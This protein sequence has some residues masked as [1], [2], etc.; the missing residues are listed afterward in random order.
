MM[1]IISILTG[2]VTGNSAVL[3]MGPVAGNILSLVAL[4][5]ACA[6]KG[7]SYHPLL[8]L[9]DEHLRSM[10]RLMVPLA[11]SS[12][13]LEVNQI[14]DK[15]LASSLAPGT[16][17]SLNYAV[18]ISNVI[19]ALI[20]TAIGTALYPKLSELAAEDNM[21]ALKKYITN[22]LKGLLPLLLPL[23]VGVVL[24]AHPIIRIL[25]ERG[26]FNSRDTARTAECLQMYA[27]GILSANLNSLLTRAFYAMRQAKS[28]AVLS[29]A[30]VVVGIAINFL[31]IGVLQHKGLALA[32]SAA[33]TLCFL[34][35]LVSLRRKIGALGLRNHLSEIGKPMLASIVMGTYIVAMM[36]IVSMST[37]NSYFHCI[38]WT[39]LISGSASALYCVVMIA[40]RTK[41][42][43]ILR[44]K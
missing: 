35:L 41:I 43:A 16:V 39:A 14:I 24:M 29:A 21:D 22:G 17:S 27:I 19:T 6:K 4:A 7:L 25:L 9:K 2:R 13:V 44:L 42:L 37:I 3:G 26:S 1:I 33:N 5:C 23:T 38:I 20:G 36:K 8:N 15:S 32:T 18:K 34:M 30:S 11:L 40:M 12:A 10:F 28:L 31:L